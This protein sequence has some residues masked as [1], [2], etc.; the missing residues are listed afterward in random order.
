MDEKDLNEDQSS[1]EAQGESKSDENNSK[2][3]SENINTP[4]LAGQN[5]SQV[6]EQ[7]LF[8][9]TFSSFKILVPPSSFPILSKYL[10]EEDSNEN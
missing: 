5:F 1:D 2:S 6:I 3:E 8:V 9:A 4:Q 7:N 10:D